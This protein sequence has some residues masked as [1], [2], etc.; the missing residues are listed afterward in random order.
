MGKYQN[1]KDLL[2]WKQAMNLALEIYEVVK[3]FPKS[4]IYGLTSQMRRAAVS[5]PSNIAEGQARGSEKE[6]KLFLN[7]AKG[8][9]A[10]LETQVFLAERLEYIS[11]GQKEK[12][13]NPIQ[14]TGKL[15]NGL[16][17]S[18]NKRIL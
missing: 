14:T 13:I 16:I 15:L 5:I 11:K 6:F 18:L 4:E 8:S 7:I 2:V 12:I 9:L 3:L 1:Y 10:E 17:R